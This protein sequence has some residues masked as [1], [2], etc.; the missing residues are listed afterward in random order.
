MSPSRFGELGRANRN[1]RSTTRMTDAREKETPVVVDV[2]ELHTPEYET[3]PL[4]VKEEKNPV[5]EAAKMEEDPEQTQSD[6]L[7]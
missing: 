1:T 6:T 7:R 5:Q 3:N 2:V 4:T